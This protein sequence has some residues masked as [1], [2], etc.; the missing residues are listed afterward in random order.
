M[1][2]LW[3]FREDDALTLQQN[4]YTSLEL[5][6]VK[7]M[8]AAWETHSFEGRY[9]EMFAVVHD[10]RIVGSIS[11]YG[12]TSSVASIGPDIFV[13]ERKKG[14]AASAME[15]LLK[16]AAEKGYRIIQQQVRTNNTASIRLH[17]KLRF[18]TDGY[19]YQNR[20]HNAVFIYLK[21]LS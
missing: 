19:A 9:F 21:A 5:D 11:L 13:H 16:L 17:E 1:T 12:L 14:F 10:H 2:E 3:P 18:E 20:H 7:Q 4:M 8:I 6:E 15:Q